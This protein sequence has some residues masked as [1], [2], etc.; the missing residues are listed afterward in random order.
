[1]LLALF[2][3]TALPNHGHATGTRGGVATSNT[4]SA[5]AAVDSQHAQQHDQLPRQLDLLGT[6]NAAAQYIDCSQELRLT[7]ICVDAEGNPDPDCQAT[8]TA[9]ADYEGSCESKMYRY[10]GGPCKPLN[11][12]SPIDHE[13]DCYDFHEGPP[14]F[15]GEEVYIVVS[16]PQDPETLHSQMWTAVGEYFW[17][18][19][20]DY[21]VG[22]PGLADVQNI[23]IYNTDTNVSFD[24]ML[25][26]FLFDAPCQGTENY[27]DTLDFN[28]SVQLI[29]TMVDP[30]VQGHFALQIEA[31][32]N[33]TQQW[34]LKRAFVS[35]T[36]E[37][38]SAVTPQY[39]VVPLLLEQRS[40]TPS[41]EPMMISTKV[42]Y[43]PSLHVGLMSSVV[44]VTPTGLECRLDSQLDV[45]PIDP[46]NRET[47]YGGA[48]QA[49]EAT[50][51]ES[52]ATSPS[53]SDNPHHHSAQG[54]DTENLGVT[55][56][57]P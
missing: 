32:V 4:D 53:S 5:A 57:E 28:Q 51:R 21:P 30:H 44:A 27:L 26:T 7:L 49:L 46:S 9:A 25:Q 16:D 47:V 22:S 11:F 56:K 12:S 42:Q 43:D 15:E 18:D 29:G 3:S 2:L 34:Q 17:T 8:R 19:Y 45:Y 31:A 13:E 48:V 33:T 10:H 1:M 35:A 20:N 41:G 38:E 36:S 6:Y 39:Q 23:S 14:S 52:E 37:S 55:P 40:V 24:N 54:K 50:N